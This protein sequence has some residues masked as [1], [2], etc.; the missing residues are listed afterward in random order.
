MKVKYT[1]T[2][3]IVKKASAVE[4]DILSEVC[5][6]VVPGYWFS[7]A[8]RRGYWNG[9]QCLYS[10]RYRTFP[11]GLL[12]RIEKSLK[13]RGFTLSVEGRQKR[14]FKIRRLKGI[15]LR[16]Y[17]R[18][19]IRVSLEKQR[20]I[21]HG[22]T[23]SGKTLALAGIIESVGGRSICLVNRKDLMYQTAKVLKRHTTQE[24]G[25]VGDGNIDFQDCTVATV[26][27]LYSL[28]QRDD[29]RKWLKE[30]DV[31]I[32]D[33]VHGLGAQTFYKCA[34]RVGADIRIGMSG[35]PLSRDDNR[36]LMVIAATGEV[37][38]RQNAHDLA[39]DGFLTLPKVRVVDVWAPPVKGSYQR[40][41]ID[42]IVRCKE[43]NEVIK[44]A[45]ELFRKKNLEI[46][47]IVREI[48]HGNILKKLLNVPFVCGKDP[49]FVRSELLKDFSNV[50]CA[51]ASTIFEEGID[52]PQLQALVVACGGKSSIKTI[53][54][55][56]RGMRLKKD[57]PH[58]F[59][60]DFLDHHN[61]YLEKHS[62]RRIELYKGYGYD[63]K[64][65]QL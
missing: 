36:N 51:I 29:V 10:K 58:F 26:Q 43:R 52:L 15:D 55:V 56:G 63:V 25:L 3:S 57:Y 31:M 12:D 62:R 33:E 40:V 1:P 6:F 4:E 41:R 37:I 18:E 59:V 48:E 14:R 53:Q 20:G 61:R 49:S 19:A 28:L 45:V 47:V 39:K 11:S 16:G 60:V 64:F 22:P 42:G 32:A 38:F 2:Y 44:K 27:T 50:G 23:G 35:T 30:C 9:R 17:Q 65:A 7:D 8:Y 5:S 34:M 13:E 46:L 54:R 21:I 24:V